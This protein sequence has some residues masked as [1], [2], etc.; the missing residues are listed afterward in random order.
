MPET[1]EAESHRRGCRR[2]RGRGRH[3][4]VR[5]RSDVGRERRR[6]AAGR[7]HGRA[8]H[9]HRRQHRRRPRRPSP[10]SSP[11]ARTR[12]PSS[13]GR[14][15]PSCSPRSTWSTSTAS[16]SRSRRRTSPRTNLKDGAELV[17]LGAR[18]DP[19]GAT[20][21]TTSRS[22]S[23]RASPTRTSGPTRS[24]ARRYAEIV[25]DDLS[26]ARPG[27]RAA[28]TRRN[29]DRFAALIDEL[30]T[31][32]RD[33]VRDDPAGA[34]KLLTYHDAYAYFAQGLRLGRSSARSRSRTSRTRRRKEVA[35]LI[36]QV[37]PEQVPAIFGSEVFPSPV[38]EQIGAETGV[39]YVDVLRDDDLPGEPGDPEHS[40]VGLMRFDYVTMTEALGGDAAA[41]R[42]VR[43]AGRR[44]RRGGLPAVTD[45]AESDRASRASRCRYGAELGAR[46]RRPRIEHGRSSS[47]SS[48]RP[49]RARRRCCAALIG[50]MAP[51]AGVVTRA[52]TACGS[53]T[54]RRWRP[55]TGTSR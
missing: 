41:L 34:R 32:M 26:R 20:T 54:C 23:R 4:R 42:G 8:D 35:D 6:E 30:D 1:L 17:E 55:S 25:R 33:V 7:D 18:D 50:T 29:Y 3:R 10:A 22:P 9:Q 46:R 12:T 15:S 14:A 52:A 51:S 53:A 36:D 47:A 5:R 37:E 31:A 45:A 40:W 44:P 11:R 16:S 39:R 21:S 27:Q 49:A 13:R 28:T 19:R 38:L 48:G 43:R 24:Y 2:P